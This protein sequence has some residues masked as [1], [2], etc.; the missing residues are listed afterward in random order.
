MTAQ[1]IA[2]ASVRYD[3]GLHATVLEGASNVTDAHWDGNDLVLVTG[4]GLTG[5]EEVI[6]TLGVENNAAFPGATITPRYSLRPASNEVRVRFASGGSSVQSSATIQV[7]R[8]AARPRLTL[9]GG[10]TPPPP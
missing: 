2:D 3:T 7:S 9:A 8:P 4:A 10:P 5:D 1:P 6:V